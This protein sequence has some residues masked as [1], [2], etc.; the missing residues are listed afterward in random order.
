MGL[1]KIYDP[2]L[3]VKDISHIY[4]NRVTTQNFDFSREFFKGPEV[5]L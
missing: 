2:R 5:F 1:V 4:D 3:K